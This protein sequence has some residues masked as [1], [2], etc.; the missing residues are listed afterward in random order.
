MY[1]LTDVHQLLTVR[2]NKCLLL[3]QITLVDK[4]EDVLTV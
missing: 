3:V 4:P 2:R 1:V